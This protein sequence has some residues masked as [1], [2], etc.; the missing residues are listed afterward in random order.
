MHTYCLK[1]YLNDKLFIYCEVILI[2]ARE[3]DDACVI[4]AAQSSSRSSRCVSVAS[5]VDAV[6]HNC[7]QWRAI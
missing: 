2:F 1:L 4:A 7:E 5:A 3:T 6:S